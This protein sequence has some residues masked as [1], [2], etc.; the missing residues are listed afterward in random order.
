MGELRGK[1]DQIQFRKRNG[2]SLL[3][4]RPFGNP[5]EIATGPDK[6]QRTLRAGEYSMVYKQRE[7]VAYSEA[8]YAAPVVPFQERV[9]RSSICGQDPVSPF[10][11]D[12]RRR[13]CGPLA[14]PRTQKFRTWDILNCG[15]FNRFT[16]AGLLVHNCIVL[17]FL[18]QYPDLGLVRPAFILSKDEDDAKEMQRRI[19]NSDKPMDLVEL[20]QSVV[21]DRHKKLKEKLEENSKKKA[22]TI[23]ILDIACEDM[24]EAAAV[25]VDYVPLSE[26]HSQPPT[27]AQ[28]ATL[29][30]HGIDLREVQDKGHASRMIDWLH[31]RI[32]SGLA[33]LKQ[34]RLMKRLGISCDMTTTFDEATTKLNQRLPF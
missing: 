15:R 12:D 23:S 1:G 9:P 32:E 11:S 3:G 6:Q 28:L 4:A 33:T 10:L 17:D 24:S 21:D 8:F 27:S 16:A 26:W 13:D 18:W 25:I 19:E 20:H 2:S 34:I 22:K 29:E 7:Y 30:R 31:N 5:S 14:S